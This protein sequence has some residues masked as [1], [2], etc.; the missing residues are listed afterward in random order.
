MPTNSRAPA[1]CPSVR[2]ANT[3]NRCGSEGNCSTPRLQCGHGTRAVETLSWISD[4]GT[5]RRCFN[6]ATAHRPWRLL[7]KDEPEGSGR[8]NHRTSW[9]TNPGKPGSL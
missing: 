9:Q 7:T 8:R 6:V 3:E 4:R 1:P 2:E 5:L